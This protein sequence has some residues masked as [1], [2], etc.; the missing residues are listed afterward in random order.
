M[1]LAA[2]EGAGGVGGG[3]EGVRDRA[4]ASFPLPFQEWMSGARD[5][6]RS[7][8]AREMFASE[9]IEVVYADPSR[10]WALAW[11]SAKH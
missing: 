8:A 9:A 11:P 1:M 10:A 4:K 3:F 2:P 7:D 5:V 6:L